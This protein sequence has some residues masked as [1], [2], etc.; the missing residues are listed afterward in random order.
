MSYALDLC[1]HLFLSAVPTTVTFMCGEPIK[2]AIFHVH[3]SAP[4]LDSTPRTGKKT[5]SFKAHDVR[6]RALTVCHE[7]GSSYVL[8]VASDGNLKM[9]E[10]ASEAVLRMVQSCELEARITC[11]CATADQKAENASSGAI[12]PLRWRRARVCSALSLVY[13]AVA[14]YRRVGSLGRRLSQPLL[15]W[16]YGDARRR[17]APRGTATYYWRRSEYSRQG[18]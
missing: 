3:A 11:M 14:L 8:S 18:S 7:G 2:V 9:W 5:A 10:V 4:Q 16:D 12:T 13:L 15:P 1:G 6:V 17:K